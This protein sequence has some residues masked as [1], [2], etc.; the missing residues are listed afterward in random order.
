MS[1][2]RFH[3]PPD[4]WNARNLALEGDE[5]RHCTQVM[6]REVGHELIAFNGAGEWARCR[7][8]A[9]SKDRV[10]LASES[11]GTTPKPKVGLALL[12]AIPRA[13]NMELI[14]EK[15]V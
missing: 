12:Q 13:G 7:I 15:A 4:R 9:L 8:T 3:V 11:V 10:D 2:P 6:R 1:L 14:I 5:A